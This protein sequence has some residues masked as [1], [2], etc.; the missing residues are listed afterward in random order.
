MDYIINYVNNDNIL[1]YNY[2]KKSNHFIF[3]IDIQILHYTTIL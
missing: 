3:Y 2:I 1:S